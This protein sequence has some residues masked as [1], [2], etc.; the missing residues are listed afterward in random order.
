VSLR[1][2]LRG[3]FIA[4]YSYASYLKLNEIYLYICVGLFGAV[5]VYIVPIVF[6]E[7][8]RTVPKHT[9]LTTSILIRSSGAIFNSAAVLVISKYLDVKT[10]EKGLIA[11]LFFAVAFV[12]VGLFDIIGIFVIGKGEP[13]N[14]KQKSLKISLKLSEETS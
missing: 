4:V 11:C 13:A 14:A 3:L 5:V 6:E 8:V 9:L 12:I 1:I 7:F 10:R 2:N